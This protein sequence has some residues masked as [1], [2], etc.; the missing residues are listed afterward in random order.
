M[1]ASQIKLLYR[2]EAQAK[3][4]AL[5]EKSEKEHQN[6]IQEMKELD[7]SLEQDRKLKEFMAT[8]ISDRTEKG[9]AQKSEEGLHPLCNCLRL[10]F[11]LFSTRFS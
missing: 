10:L 7:R 6:Y 11:I 9:D 8:K 2:D 5:R 1:K 4:I 3:I